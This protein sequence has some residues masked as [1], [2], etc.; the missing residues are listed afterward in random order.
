MTNG[1]ISYSGFHACS[2]PITV[3]VK[4]AN[5]TIWVSIVCGDF[6]FTIFLEEE[7]GNLLDLVAELDKARAELSIIAG[8]IA[9]NV[10]ARYNSTGERI[11]F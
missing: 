10:G 8:K 9:D 11:T 7:P 4:E 6:N 3:N 1:P 5:S 2:T